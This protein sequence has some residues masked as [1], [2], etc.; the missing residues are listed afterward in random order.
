MEA[1][2]GRSSPFLWT[3]A[4]FTVT[5][6]KKQGCIEIDTGGLT[7]LD[8]KSLAKFLIEWAKQKGELNEG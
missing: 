4:S 2:R 7:P 5:R 3:G 1:K 6:S 8:A